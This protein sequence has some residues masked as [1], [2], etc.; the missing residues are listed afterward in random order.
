MQTQVLYISFIISSD[1]KLSKS[2][3]KLQ[4]RTKV[5]SEHFLLNSGKINT[6]PEEV[7][8]NL[9]RG[10]TPTNTTLSIIQPFTES[11]FNAKEQTGSQ[12]K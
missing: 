9:P 3:E 7:S 1:R 6:K 4:G 2:L 11:W 5:D 12:G 10:H 8:S